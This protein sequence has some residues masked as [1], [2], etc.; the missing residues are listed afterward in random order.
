[1]P[2][3]LTTIGSVPVTMPARTL[4]D[5]AGVVEPDAFEACLAD[6]LRLGL[7]S[8]DR[9]RRLFE[10][11]GGR[12]RRGSRHVRAAL[13]T[14]NGRVES[15]LEYKVL[16]LLHSS[17]LP[18]PKGQY[19]VWDGGTLLARVDF[20]YPQ[21]KLAIEADGYRHHGARNAWEKDLQRR[22]ALTARGWHV[23][24]VT[25]ADATNRPGEIAEEIR[26]AVRL[27]TGQTSFFPS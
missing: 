14:T 7:T 25:W 8:Q 19:E 5:L 23:I 26:E 6:A 21:I 3:E 9:L 24:H 2:S 17:K 13:D 16:R 10:R 22:N 11:S 12:G 20:A 1:M 27:L 4:L 18:P 15:I